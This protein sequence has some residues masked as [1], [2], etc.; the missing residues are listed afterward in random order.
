MFWLV[1][2]VLGGQGTLTPVIV[3]NA[4]EMLTSDDY[5]SR[6][7]GTGKSGYTVVE[8]LIDPTGKP[9]TCGVVST[10]GSKDLDLKACAAGVLRGKYAPAT[11]ETGSP[12]YGVYRMRV[13]WH[14]ELFFDAST[15]HP[16][17]RQTSCWKS[18]SCRRGRGP[19]LSPW[20]IWSGK[21]ARSDAVRL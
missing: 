15:L 7:V 16:R 19:L 18:R 20:P 21:T 12:M 2:L 10:S 5:V 6:A 13:R 1:M 11:D 3:R 4:S 14:M 8:I 9:Q 17:C